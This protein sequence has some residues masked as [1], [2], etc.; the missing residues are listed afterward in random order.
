MARSAKVKVI[1]KISEEGKKINN[2]NNIS[3]NI[4]INIKM[5]NKKGKVSTNHI[6]L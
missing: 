1:K 6:L 4:N 3:I 2:N 5:N